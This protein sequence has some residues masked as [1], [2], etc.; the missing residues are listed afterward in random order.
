MFYNEGQIV[1]A[2]NDSR[3]LKNLVLMFLGLYKSIAN[4]VNGI[5]LTNESIRFVYLHSIT[6]VNEPI[7]KVS[8]QNTE[9]ASY[10]NFVPD[11]DPDYE[12]YGTPGHY[13]ESFSSH[14]IFSSIDI[15]IRLLL[16]TKEEMIAYLVKL[17]TK[18]DIDEAERVRLEK[19]ARLQ[20]E[21]A[22]LQK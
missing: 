4:K 7:I 16:L 12:G 15:P 1:K 11:L 18:W 3:D 21:L 19:V 10:S 22:E 13:E 9:T 14:V 5:N 6:N 20:K 17:K 2:F 8:L